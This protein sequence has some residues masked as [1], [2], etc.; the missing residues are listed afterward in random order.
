MKKTIT[1]LLL[2]VCFIPFTRAQFYKSVLPTPAFSDSIS[3][4]VQ[5]FKM[6]FSTIEGSQLV[7]RQEMDVYRSTITIPGALHCAIYRFHSAEDTTASWQAIMYE[8]D[9][10]ED[11]IKIYKNTFRQLK[12]IRIK[13]LDKSN[14]SF[15]G[16]LEM[17]AENIRFAV[18]TLRLNTMDIAFEYFFGE[19][20]LIS[21]Y[22]GWEVHLNL[23]RK[24]NDSK[25]Y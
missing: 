5:D 18:T 14:I 23:H 2:F 10:Y 21:N 9:S 17:P 20:E 25:K 13:G 22:D 8:G 3:I 15:T 1:L 16:E 7:S 12:K 6:N 4:I 19:I 24:K 11:A